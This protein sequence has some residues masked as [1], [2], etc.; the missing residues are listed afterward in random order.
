MCTIISLL[1]CLLSGSNSYIPTYKKNFLKFWWNEELD[2]LKE[3]SITSNRLW[4]AAGKPRQGPVFN[5]R[6]S[7][8]AQYRRRIRECQAMTTESY[9]NDLH[10]ALLTKDNTTF[11]K[12]W[13][14]KFESANK[15]VQV[16]GCVD[17]GII[18]E[19]FNEHF[20]K[21][22]SC[23]NVHRAESLKDEYTKLRE[24]YC[25][26][27]LLDDIDFDTE[28]VSSV[29]LALKRGKA[30]DIAG[31]SA[32]HLQYCHPMLSVILSKFF[33]LILLSRYIPNG[34]KHSYI[35]PIPK[36]KDCRTK[37]MT[38]NDFRGIAISP[39][40]SKVFEHCLLKHL[41]LFLASNDNQFG[42]K[43]GLGCSH[44]IYTVRNIVNRF[45][46]EGNTVNLCAIDLSKAFD[47][48]NHH[49][50]YI[51]LM[52]RHIPAQYLSIIEN[53]FSNCYTCIKW[54]NCWSADFVINFGVRQGSVLS[55]FL[56]AM[57]IDG[58]GD[59]CRPE[60]NYI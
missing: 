20:S 5:K 35:V 13:R 30:A 53:L 15:C 27:P 37:A 45:V 49:A 55:P 41:Q 47:K 31:L 39:I 21:A 42:F 48:V 3:A 52:K 18:V 22:Y 43:K 59:L 4:K 16:E 36:I 46:A 57:Y 1:S 10:E 23:N 17:P 24:D 25:G 33:R 8:R 44:A 58:I 34:F 40:L 29:I 60:C 26:F 28:M 54:N 12:C 50:L 51:K 56:F 2:Q 19:K 11:W 6:Q 7:C 38:C 14:S 9:T 32:E